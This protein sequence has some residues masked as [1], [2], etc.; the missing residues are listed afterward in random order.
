[1]L[2]YRR[3]PLARMKRE[4]GHEPF[5]TLFNFVDFHVYDA[6]GE[7]QDLAVDGG[8]GF[9]QTNFAYELSVAK[10]PGTGVVAIQVTLDPE[11]GTAEEAQAIVQLYEAVLG[12]LGDVA[13]EAGRREAVIRGGEPPRV[14]DRVA[15]VARATGVCAVVLARGARRR[16]A[17]A[18][19]PPGQASPR[20]GDACESPRFRGNRLRRAVASP[21]DCRPRGRDAPPRAPRCCLL[22]VLVEAHGPA[23][24][25]RGRLV[26]RDHR[27]GADCARAGRRG[28]RSSTWC[29]R[30]RLELSVRRSIGSSPSQSSSKGCRSMARRGPRSKPRSCRGP[31]RG[32]LRRRSVSPWTRRQSTSHCR[33]GRAVPA[34]SKSCSTTTRTCLRRDRVEDDR[35]LR[36]LPLRVRV[37]RAGA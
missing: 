33:G 3:Y 28:R 1:M 20:P 8:S 34:R 4:L 32:R 26:E 35:A 23:G 2:P 17:G 9:E 29:A 13:G 18:R 21:G 37:A 12:R 30:S 6:L 27:G 24:R 15:R 22:R 5:E 7:E 31:R 14:L 10:M 11:I 25:C 19:A 36:A 16:A